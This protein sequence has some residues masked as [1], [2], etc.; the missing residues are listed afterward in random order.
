M[1][2]LQEQE[3]EHEHEHE[4]ESFWGVGGW[5]TNKI[6]FCNSCFPFDPLVL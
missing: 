6:R 2:R 4:H 3:L 1:S 5:P